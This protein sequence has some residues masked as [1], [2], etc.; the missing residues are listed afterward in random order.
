MITFLSGGTGTPKLI[1]GVR[2]HIRDDEIA[3]VVNT[4]EDIWISGNHMSPDIDTVM[5]LFLGILNTSTWWG[6]EDDTFTT[7]EML[8]KFQPDEYI[9]IG[10]RDRAVQIARGELLRRGSTLTGATMQLC[11]KS[12]ISASVLPMADT[13]VTT[14]VSASGTIMHFQEYWVRNKGAVPIDGVMRIPNPPPQATAEVIAAIKDADAVVIGPSNPVTSILPILECGGTKS[15]LAGK[16]VIAVS[17]FI[18]NVPFS[19]PAGALMQAMG[20]EPS[21]RGTWELYKDFIDV[22]VQDIRD[23]VDVT[24][25][26]RLDTMMTDREK[27]HALAGEICRIAGVPARM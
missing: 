25:S 11:L 15:A 16:F 20:F 6:I 14:M 2:G 26:V 9:A 8:K 24:G 21:S 4:G 10:D 13:P 18:G 22:F 12:G 19:G 17:P 3:V 5:Y 1:W 27:S 23:P 7:H